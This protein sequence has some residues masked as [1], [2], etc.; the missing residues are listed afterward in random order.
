MYSLL[1]FNDI[2][3]LLPWKKCTDLYILIK[4]HDLR[5]F[6]LDTLF[7]VLEKSY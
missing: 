3:S 5:F 2:T 1:C 4:L 6:D 7:H